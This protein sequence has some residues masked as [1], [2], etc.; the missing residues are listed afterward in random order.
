M[1][2]R[3]L[4]PDFLLEKFYQDLLDQHNIP[5]AEL[6]KLLKKH[7]L[8]PILVKTLFSTVLHQHRSLEVWGKKTELKRTLERIVDDSLAEENP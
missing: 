7:N 6:L 5:P 8:D 3:P 1:A 2:Q 4:D